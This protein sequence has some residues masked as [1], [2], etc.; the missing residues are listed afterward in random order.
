MPT[1]Q[2]SGVTTV[3]ISRN[4]S[5]PNPICPYGKSAVHPSQTWRLHRPRRVRKLEPR[6]LR[7]VTIIE[8]EHA[9]EALT[10]LDRA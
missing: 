1:Q 8:L 7:G 9:A 6:V 5:R 2:L 10:A 3:A 4:R